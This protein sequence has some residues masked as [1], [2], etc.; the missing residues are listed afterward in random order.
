MPL[1]E[2]RG[3][4]SSLAYG[5][6]SFT[7]NLDPYFNDVTFLSGTLTSGL[8]NNTILDS[9]PN[10]FVITRYG[11]VAQGSFNPFME[12][13]SMNFGGGGVISIAN[14]SATNFGTADFTVEFWMKPQIQNST[15][16]SPVLGGTTGMFLVNLVSPTGELPN[17]IAINSYGT[18]PHWTSPTYSFSNKWQHVAYVRQSGVGKLYID[19][20]LLHSAADTV[21]YGGGNVTIGGAGDVQRY[22]GHLSDVRVVKSAV[23][24]S[25]FMPPTSKLSAIA[26]TTVLTLRA[27]RLLDESLSPTA[28]TIYAGAPRISQLDPYGK[29]SYSPSIHGGSLSFDGNEDYITIPDNTNIEL[30]SGNFTIEMWAWPRTSV[31]QNAEVYNKTY[32]I[33]LYLADGLWRWYGS[34][35][36][37]GTT[38][39]ILNAFN[40]GA[41]RA[42]EWQH[43][44]LVRNGNTFTSYFNG[45]VV[46]TTTA[47]GAFENNSEPLY[48]GRYGT[49]LY[50]YNGYLS[51]IRLAKDV[52]YSSS[53]TPPVS[54]P[55]NT[56]NTQ[57][58]INAGNS[59]VYD[60]AT[61]MNLTLN[62]T[63]S[64]SNS[65][66][67]YGATSLGFSGN[68]S[69][70]QP[71]LATNDATLMQLLGDFTVE[72]WF[73]FTRLPSTRPD[74]GAGLIDFRS[75][76]PSSPTGLLLY[77]KA[78][79]N[80]FVVYSGGDQIVSTTTIELNVWYHVAISRSGSSIRLFV[81]GIQQGTTWTSSAKFTDN[82]F[83]I[84][85]VQDNLSSTYMKFEGYMDDIRVTTG[86]SRY[87]SNFNPPSEMASVK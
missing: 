27:N 65:V 18:G 1:L 73:Y 58:L 54:P 35:G 22:V 74:T 71:S 67:K 12:N 13:Y 7:P 56:S 37:Q 70:M 26:N 31:T 9:S 69:S 32:G 76:T 80:K 20:S 64:S 29:V 11:D 34:T 33:Q 2:T 59:G 68:S 50:P 57:L 25:N 8:N 24:T 5:L 6:N 47:S 72:G 78:A 3:S 21:S 36:G 28:V 14:S 77:A 75:S 19:G 48:I 23:Y 38:Y 16:A 4:A 44:A 43:V 52:I 46:S 41:A 79:D 81:N 86:I 63:L 51:S 49:G 45:Q 84:S 40:G 60:K 85:G 61:G 17:Q 62:G 83:L 42:N 82:L 10:N 39:D 55:T 15:Y 30:G 66:V 53:F 87:T